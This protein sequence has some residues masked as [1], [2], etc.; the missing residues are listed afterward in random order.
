MRP[1]LWYDHPMT[2]AICQGVS[3][4]SAAPMGVGLLFVVATK[5]WLCGRHYLAYTGLAS[6]GKRA[7]DGS[8]AIKQAWQAAGLTTNA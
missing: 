5:Q 6:V 2:C 7:S 4:T 3:P 8:G 1:I